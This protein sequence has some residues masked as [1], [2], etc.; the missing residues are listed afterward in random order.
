MVNGKGVILDKK[1]HFLA[2]HHW[3][4]A[5]RETIPGDASCR[6]YQRLRQ[7]NGKT[8]IL[9]DSSQQKDSV[10]PFVKVDSFLQILS[11]SAPE[12]YAVDKTNGFILMEDFGE[13]SFTAVL[14]GNAPVSKFYRHEL[15]LYIAATQTLL[16]LGKHHPLESLMPY[17]KAL[18]IEEISLFIDWY[19]PYILHIPVG[20][21]C[22][23]R[24]LTIW[25]NLLSKFYIHDEV[26]VLRDYHADNLIWLPARKPEQRVGLLDFQD[27][28]SGSPLYDLVSLLEDARRDVARETYQAVINYY[29]NTSPYKKNHF[30]HDFAILAAQRNCKIIGIFAR[31]AIRDQKS[32]YLSFLPRV[33]RHLH[34]DLTHP[35]LKPLKSWLVETLPEQK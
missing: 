2:K 15:P 17:S 16:A 33:W 34:N 29:L 19:L 5:A 12:L 22:R 4:M 25:E 32:N 24:Y 14:A 8:A 3:H 26:T 31:L 18:M 7:E 6:H 1:E 10:G 11:L 21:E 35:V 13:N 23:N 28:V 27:A 20:K 9:M 30:L